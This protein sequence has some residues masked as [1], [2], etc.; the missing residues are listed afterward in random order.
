M[1]FNLGIFA[2]GVADGY[3]KQNED[4]RKQA[5][6]KRRQAEYEREEAY[7]KETEGLLT[8]DDE[9]KARQAEHEQV[10]KKAEVDSSI[11]KTAAQFVGNQ[12]IYTQGINLPSSGTAPRSFSEGVVQRRMGIDAGADEPTTPPVRSV[13]SS[14]IDADAAALNEIVTPKQAAQPEAPKAPGMHEWMDFATKRAAIDVKYGKMNG[15]GMLQLAQARKQLVSENVDEA[16]MKIHQGDVEGGLAAFNAA[17]KYVGAK[18]VGAPQR[19]EFEMNGVKVPTTIVTLRLPD[20]RTETVNTAQYGMGRIKMEDLYKN[21]VEMMKLQNDKD[22][23]DKHLELLGSELG[24]KRGKQGEEEREAKAK[25]DAGVAIYLQNNPGATK[26]QL[27]G[28]RHGIIKAVPR[29]NA[30][31]Y[32]VK[33]GE[34]GT[35]ITRLHKPTGLLETIDGQSGKVLSRIQGGAPSGERMVIAPDGTKIPESQAAAY[36]EKLAQ[37][38]SNSPENKQPTSAPSTP[39]IF[40]PTAAKNSTPTARPRDVRVIQAE[41]NQLKELPSYV[42]QDVKDAQRAKREQLIA[43]RDAA[44]GVKTPT[45]SIGSLIGKYGIGN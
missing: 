40:N 35:T 7:R 42:N 34:G 33:I 21:S 41:L 45:T 32:E 23:K 17:G 3:R 15:L 8:P 6:E 24:M 18:P 30:D 2:G 29:E 26:E 5:E 36:A 27:E 4:M 10:K 38:K 25:A 22:Y 37:Q 39:I 14:G 31:D 43:E 13:V 1:G 9:Y 11:A 19:A 20:G 44:M 16:V 12:P 28:V